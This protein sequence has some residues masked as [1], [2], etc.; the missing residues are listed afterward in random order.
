MLLVLQLLHTLANSCNPAYL[1]SSSKCVMSDEDLRSACDSR[2]IK[3]VFIGAA[4]KLLQRHE[5]YIPRLI[6]DFIGGAVE[7]LAKKPRLHFCCTVP[8]VTFTKDVSLCNLLISQNA[9]ACDGESRKLHL[10]LE[11]ALTQVT[12]LPQFSKAIKLQS[13]FD[14][15]PFRPHWHGKEPGE[16]DSWAQAIQKVNKLPHELVNIF[17]VLSVE[18]AKAIRANLEKQLSY[19]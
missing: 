12:L 15:T 4:D 10:E 16:E 6:R 14:G 19:V 2:S 5:I 11:V 8:F 1:L 3:C 17:K 7:I 9:A 13:V 18:Q